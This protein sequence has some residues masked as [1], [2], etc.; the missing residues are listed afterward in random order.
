MSND[1]ALIGEDSAVF[2]SRIANRV[3]E[4]FDV[5]ALSPEEAVAAFLLLERIQATLFR[6]HKLVLLPLYKEILHLDLSNDNDEPEG[7]G[8]NSN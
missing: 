2:L 1:D 7:S 8:G 6:E 3:A 5:A 4:S